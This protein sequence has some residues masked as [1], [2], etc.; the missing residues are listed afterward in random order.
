M[1]S[2]AL[3][4]RGK[5][6]PMARIDLALVAAALVILGSACAMADPGLG[7]PGAPAQLEAETYP[8]TRGPI[9]GTLHGE[10]TGCLEADVEGVSR[11]VIWPPGTQL[12][13]EGGIRLPDGTVVRPGDR[14]TGVGAVTP[15]ARLVA[16]KGY[17][18]SLIGF[19]D[20]AEADA[21]VFDQ[22]APADE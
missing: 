7:G 12:G 10:D 8:G 15:I 20:P 14:V 18:E 6:R 22:V 2:R 1:R 17:W 11:F 19:C 16:D 21:L 5:L 4:Q 3:N 9:T 13:D